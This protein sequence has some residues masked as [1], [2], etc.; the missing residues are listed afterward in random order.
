MPKLCTTCSKPLPK[1]RHRAVCST[2]HQIERQLEKLRA[3]VLTLSTI[4]QGIEDQYKAMLDRYEEQPEIADDIHSVY[5]LGIR[6]SDLS[7]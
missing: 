2:C 4:M 5:M 1:G 6:F 7:K 3:P